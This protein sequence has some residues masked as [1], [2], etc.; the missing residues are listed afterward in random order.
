MAKVY[1]SAVMAAPIAEVWPIIRD[2]SGIGRFGPIVA[3]CVIEGGEPA[4]KLG[5]IR[6]IR[7]H[8][9]GM[10]R[11][12]LVALDDLEHVLRYSI[13][14][15]GLGVTD[16]VGT[17]RA[18]SVTDGDGTFVEWHASFGCAPERESELVAMLGGGV[19]GPGLQVMKG[20]VA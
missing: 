10:I 7:T 4:D 19:F 16:Y 15:S 9:G 8:D 5:C 11:E 13:V 18:I 12:R 3:T 17:M 6:D 20:L 2:F 1:V 14:E